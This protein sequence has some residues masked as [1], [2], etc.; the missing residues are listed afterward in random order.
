LKALVTGGPGF[1]GSHLVEALLKKGVE[2]R[3]LV[4]RSSDLK[5]IE[6]LPVEF[7]WGDC[8]DR[9]SLAEAVKGMDVVFHSAGVTKV[10]REESFFQVNAHG[11][12]NLIQAC[13]DNAPHL[14]KFIYLSSQAA[15]GP[16]LDGNRKTE[17]DLCE[18]VSPYGRSK[19]MGEE[20]A[21]ARSR[22]LP[23]VILRPS[24]IY[25]PRDRDIY[26][27]FKF[28]SRRI[29]PC[30]SD[31]D[32]RV[33]LCHVQDLVQAA[34]LAGDTPTPQGEIFFVSDGQDYP[35]Q[36]IGKTFARAMGVHAFRLC[37][38]KWVLLGMASFSEYVSCVSKRP[39][40]ISR[41]KVA[42]MIQKNWVCDITKARTVLG[43]KPSI[44]LLD[45][46]RM[47]VDWYRNKNWL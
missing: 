5:W 41:G 38:P 14:Q 6:G 33:S 18:P 32:Q 13:L 42:E 21:L 20:L 12:E 2:V 7:A 24:A 19:R 23:L 11:T 10:V 37:V 22:Q 31:P 28:L 8:T 40:L 43:Y 16:S 17:T 29:H 4:R 30:L 45:G 47:T 3:C 34:L 26:V 39:S 35:F 25:G 44:G 15:A 46:A 27:F 36:D 1:I 9:A